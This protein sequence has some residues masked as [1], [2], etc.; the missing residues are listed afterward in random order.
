MK[1]PLLLSCLLLQSCAL[2]QRHER[3]CDAVAVGAAAL[4]IGSLSASDWHG[5]GCT[6]GCPGMPRC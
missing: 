5:G 4:V 2:C 6:C 3:T 1:L